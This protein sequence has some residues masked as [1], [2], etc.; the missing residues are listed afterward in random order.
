MPSRES[1]ASKPEQHQLLPAHC[2][3]GKSNDP[4]VARVLS[5]GF[6]NHPEIPRLK[7]D[8]AAINIVTNRYVVNVKN[9]FVVSFLD[10]QKAFV[11]KWLQ[12]RDVD[13]I[14]QFDVICEINGWLRRTPRVF[15]AEV[16]DMCL[17]LGFSGVRFEI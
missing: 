15:P 8:W 2:I 7:G 1:T 6:Q 14:Y 16:H 9:P 4:L 12:H 13:N 3:V 11:K 17:K 5:T 10:R